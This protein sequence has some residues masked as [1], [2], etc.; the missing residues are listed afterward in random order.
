MD[1][2]VWAVWD[3]RGM[4]LECPSE[5][6]ARAKAEEF[7]KAEIGKPFWVMC[8]VSCAFGGQLVWRD[9]VVPDTVYRAK[10]RSRGF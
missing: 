10:S 3:G 7:A 8:G 4:I 6:E 5:M 9:Y 2:N 1:A